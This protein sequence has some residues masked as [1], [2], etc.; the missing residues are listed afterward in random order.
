M[1]RWQGH[2]GMAKM[3]EGISFRRQRVDTRGKHLSPRYI[4][5]RV[6]TNMAFTHAKTVV[7]DEMSVTM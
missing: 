2:D 4:R 1:H 6:H 5:L 7:Q 3:G